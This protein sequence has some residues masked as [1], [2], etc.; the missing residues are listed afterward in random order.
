[1]ETAGL[2]VA[3][4]AA[5]A[6]IA[7]AVIANVQRRDADRAAA[8]AREDADR[9]YRAAEAAAGAATKSARAHEMI[10]EIAE[11]KASRPPWRLSYR[12]G[13]TFDAWNDGD[14][15]VFDVTVDGP[16]V[17]RGPAVAE[18]V[19][20]GSSIVFW[21]NPGWVSDLTVSVHWSRQPG[22]EQIHWSQEKPAKPRD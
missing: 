5:L 8:E 7:S 21:G 17:I 12:Q 4:I 3:I 1:M 2:V 15:P 18:K 11:Q 10:A 13:D 22:G 14:V 20:A 9:A 6:A 16:G 19:D